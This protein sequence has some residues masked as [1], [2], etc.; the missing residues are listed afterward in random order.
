MADNGENSL[1][2]TLADDISTLDDL[3]SNELGKNPILDFTGL[4]GR[5]IEGTVSIAREANYT[6]TIGFYNIQNPNGAVRDPLTNS[7]ILPGMDG[8]QEAALDSGNLF[9]HFGALSTSMNGTI[10]DRINVF[11]EAN[12]SEAGMLAPYA[13]VKDTEETFFSFKAAN[14]DGVNHFRGFGNGVMG[15]EDTLGGFDNDF[16][17]LI[18]G[19][20]FQLIN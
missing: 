7:L 13:F 17:D 1:R 18:I 3:I 11:S 6:S 12:F 2:L 15:L 19:F 5:E 9:T 20:D 8:Y 10:E 16:D 4:S 14:A